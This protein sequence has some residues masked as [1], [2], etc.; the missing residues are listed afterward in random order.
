M[1]KNMTFKA[2][3]VTYEID[4]NK[5]AATW[6][7]PKKYTWEEPLILHGDI[8]SSIFGGN[9][10]PDQKIFVLSFG[11]VV[12]VNTTSSQNT[13]FFS[14]LSKYESN[15]DINNLNKYTEDYELKRGDSNEI[16]LN[17]EY[18]VVPNFD[19]IY[20]EL[21]STI[22][23]KSVA[24][25]RI[26]EKLGNLL[27]L[28]EN[29]INRFEKGKMLIQNKKI[30]KTLAKIVRYEY[31]TITY[32]MILDKPD[33][34]W[35]NSD[36][37]SFYTNLANFFEL[38]DRFEIIEK[39][40]HILNAIME[41]FSSISHALRGSVLEWIVIILIFIEILFSVLDHL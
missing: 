29:I 7:I 22:I 41:G 35:T 33:I 20:I 24:L 10:E 14:F 9:V 5:I 15:I 36:A 11:S 2:Y 13:K 28:V 17:N 39:K 19:A 37:E 26:E 32:I 1:I 8:L 4:L 16:E 34:T 18:A 31:D 12:F 38:N 25:E 3:A 21:V 6:N 23:A 27:D 30:A 40:T